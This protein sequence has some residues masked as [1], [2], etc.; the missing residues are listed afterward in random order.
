MD[1]LNQVGRLDLPEQTIRERLALVIDRTGLD[2]GS[3]NPNMEDTS[4]HLAEHGI[5]AFGEEK[6]QSGGR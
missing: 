2:D 4:Y 6:K 3:V 1:D 5:P